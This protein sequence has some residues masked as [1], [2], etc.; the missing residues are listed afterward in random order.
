M[1]LFEK[2]LSTNLINFLIV[3]LTLVWIIK[4]V[5]ISSLIENLASEIKLKVEE[6]SKS[7][8]LSIDEYKKTKK[9]NSSIPQLKEQIIDGAKKNAE[10]LKEKIN[11]KTL[12]QKEGLQKNLEKTIESQKEKY[13]SLTK[14]EI[15]SACVS[16]AQVELQKKLDLELQKKLINISINDLDRIGEKLC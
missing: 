2:I 4:K 5:N 7:A 15:Y 1:S 13:K 10:D 6:S 16:L 3:V 8:A 11:Q 12:N 14:K 9:Q